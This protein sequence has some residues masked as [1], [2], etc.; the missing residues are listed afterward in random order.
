MSEVAGGGIG[1]AFIAF[2]TIVSEAP[3]GAIL[4]VLFFGSLVFAGLTSLISILEVIVAAFQDKLGWSR[5]SA[6][7]IVTIPIA[8]I[9]MVLFPTTTGLLPAGHLGRVRQPVRHPCLCTGHR[10]RPDRG[11]DARFRNCRST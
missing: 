5:K 2:P 7:L 9:S 10:H 3:F 6:T 11:A 4:G 1:L 8:V